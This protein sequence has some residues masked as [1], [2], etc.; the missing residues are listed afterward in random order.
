MPALLSEDL[1]V[2]LVEAME[3]G[4]T[5]RAVGERFGVAPISVSKIHQ[6]WRRTWRRASRPPRDPCFGA[7]GELSSGTDTPR[8]LQLNLNGI[9]PCCR[10]SSVLPPSK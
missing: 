6:R 2:R 5:N 3:A 8:R 9:C 7:T 10:E 1:R 4:G